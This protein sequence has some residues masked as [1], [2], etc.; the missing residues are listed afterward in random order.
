MKRISIRI[1]CSIFISILLST[2][3]LAG[4]WLIKQLIDQP[5]LELVKKLAF[6]WSLF[7]FLPVLKNYI[8]EIFFLEEGKNFIKSLLKTI[9]SFPFSFFVYLF[10]CKYSTTL[11][12]T[13]LET[14]C[15][16]D[17]NSLTIPELIKLY[18]GFVIKNTVPISGAIA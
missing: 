11:F 17:D 10:F 4:I 2:T 5:S 3:N 9:F 7:L 12:G 6:V 13:N 18:L 14:S 16:K 8:F 15:P 1:V